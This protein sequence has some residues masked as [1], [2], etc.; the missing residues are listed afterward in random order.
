MTRILSIL[1]LA[2]AMTISGFAQISGSLS[3]AV[4]DQNQASLANATVKVFLAGGKEPVL[5]GTTNTAGRF[6]FGAVKPDLYD[7]SV[8]AS[9][10]GS[11][12]YRQAI[13]SGGR[14]TALPAFELKVQTVSQVVEV[15]ANAQTLQTENAQVSTTITAVQLNNLPVLGRQVSNL[16]ATQPGVISG[17]A[18]TSVNGLKSA[19]SNVTLDGINVQDNFIKTNDLDY[20]PFRV[21]IDQIEEITLTTSNANAQYGGGASQFIMRTKSGT[22]AYHG[23]AYWYNRNDALSSN[24]WFNNRDGVSKPRL[25][26]NQPGISLGGP[27]KR[28]KLFFFANYEWYRNKAQSTQTRTVLTDAARTGIFTYNDTTGVRR[29]ADLR[30]LRGYTPDPT[31]AGL[32]AQ[33]PKPNAPGGDGLNTSGYRFNAGANEF[34]DQFVYKTDYYLSSKQSITGSYSYIDNPTQRPGVTASFYTLQPNVSNTLKNHLLSLQW[35]WTL[36]PTLTNEV[37]M[38]FARTH[39]NFDV[40]DPYTKFLLGGLSFTNPSNTFLAQGRDT[41]TY[42]IQ[43]NATWVHG[44][45]QVSFGYQYQKITTTPFND[46]GIVPTYTLGISAANTTGLTTGDLPGVRTADLAIANGLYANLAG[47]I[48]SGSATFNVTSATSGFVPGA[49]LRRQFHNDTHALYVQDNW[50]VRRNLTVNL[51]LR[52]EYWTPLDEKNGLFIAPRLQNNSAQASLMDPNAV[53][54]FIGGS[55]GRKFY[56]SDK[57]NFAPIIGLAWTPGSGKTVVRGGYSASFVNDSLITTVRNNVTTNNGLSFANSIVN[58]TANLTNA[59]VIAAP[60]YKVPRTLADNY[61]ISTTAAAGLPDP[62]LIT[63]IV[64]QWNVSVEH[65]VKGVLVTARYLGNEGTSLLR[66]IDYNQVLYNANGFLADFRRAQSNGQL[67]QTVTGVYNGS[68]NANIQGSQPLTVFPLLAAGGNLGGAAN[69]NFLRTG[70]VGSMADTYMTGRNNGTVNF[71]TNPNLQGANSITNQGNSSYH[72]L[73]LQAT[74][75][76]R[77]GLQMQFSYTYGKSLSNVAGDGQTN[78]EPLLDN[79]NPALEN[80]RTPYDIRHTFKANYFY[81]LPFGAGKRWSGNKIVNHLMGN[82]A[83]AGIWSDQSGSPYSVLSSFGTLNRAARS[84]ATN[85]ASVAGATM[86]QLA[87]LT[88][89]V[90]KTGDNIYFLSPKLLNS[91]GRGT[92]QSGAN[93][94]AGQIFYN[95]DA[96]TL[97]NL[98]RRQFSAPWNF[99]WDMSVVKGIRVG[100]RH[101]VDL[102]FDFFNVFNHA[103][104]YVPPSTAGDFGST[105]NFNVNNTTFGQITSTTYSPR[106]IQIG[107][108]YSF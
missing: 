95:P 18:P 65:D 46:A 104:F 20:A 7:V 51:G 36:S 16:F 89:G 62:K 19:L 5:T 28:D 64:H 31:V 108:R 61:A 11:A 88:S 17:S 23:S 66:G 44:Q 30:A 47:I 83:L 72:A 37:H 86:A 39:G 56:N 74:K 35:R 91:D 27:V 9:G 96:G 87:P 81:E 98:Q 69:V 106:Q 25:N 29:T 1:V 92:A 22:N 50:K 14:E 103:A 107:A 10:F 97:G 68:Y 4:V 71:Y 13:I 41:N 76:T 8:E 93:A 32:I 73:Q 85:T 55:S 40:K 90:F 26:L 58:Q 21:T 53:L 38:G 79:A 3:G 12:T 70:Q 100:E 57:N 45:H 101:K 59:P 2:F 67:A 94:F 75:R 43:D 34:R 42:P 33:L 48:S 15:I 63:P 80:S 24:D 49:T 77:N 54:D 78:F 52:Y 99:A 84:T 102:H 6:V 105:T 82:W 60:T